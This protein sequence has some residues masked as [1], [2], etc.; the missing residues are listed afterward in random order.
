MKRTYLR[1]KSN[2]NNSTFKLYKGQIRKAVNAHRYGFIKTVI[3]LSSTRQSTTT[4]EGDE[5]K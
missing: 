3:A 1:A 4:M 5:I 2:D